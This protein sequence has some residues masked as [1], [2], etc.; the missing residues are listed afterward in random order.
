MNEGH[1]AATNK[2][3]GRE[4]NMSGPR[5]IARTACIFSPVRGHAAGPRLAQWPALLSRK[6]EQPPSR[7]CLATFQHRSQIQNG[8]VVLSWRH[9]DIS[10]LLPTAPPGALSTRR[11][12]PFGTMKRRGRRPM[13]AAVA[14]SPPR[15][16]GRSLAGRDAAAVRALPP[17]P[18]SRCGTMQ[19]GHG[20]IARFQR[21]LASHA[22]ARPCGAVG[23]TQGRSAGDR[24]NRTRL[25]QRRARFM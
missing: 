11:M 16:V 2:P 25:C 12:P 19:R 14:T 10:W 23:A 5:K 3:C 15:V 13:S 20:A 6:T 18:L 21:G 8:T 17:L 1:K 4:V 22:A 9:V 7:R 24:R